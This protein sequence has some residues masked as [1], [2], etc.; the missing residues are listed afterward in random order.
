MFR[1]N[2]ASGFKYKNFDKKVAIGLF[3][4]FGLCTLI[5]PFE[6]GV[7]EIAL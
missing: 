1:S 7:F 3:A 2:S 6:F 4:Y 5:I